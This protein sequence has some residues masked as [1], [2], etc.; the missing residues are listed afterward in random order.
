MTVKT[1]LYKKHEKSGASFGEFG[2][3]E[4]PLWY[5]GGQIKE[6]TKTRE[7]CGL[8]D[9]C[10]MG[11][12]MVTGKDS[13]SYWNRILTNNIEKIKDGQAQYSFMLN[14]KGGVVDDCILYRF[15]ET[16]WMLVV[17]AGNHENDFQWLKEHAFG[18]V[19]VENI[20]EKTGKI[21]IQGPNAPKVIA[22]IAG[23]ESIEKMKFFRFIENFDLGGFSV[24]LSRTGYTGEIGFEIYCD[25]SDAES[26]WELLLNEGKEFGITPAGLGARDT[27]RLE[28]GLPLHGHEIHPD[29]P[30][31]GTPWA[32][33]MDFSTDF[34]GKDAL[35]KA[36][37]DYYVNV[38]LLKSRRKAS[39]KAP[40]IVDG[41]EK[42]FVTSTGLAVSLD[43][44]PLAFIRTTKALEEGESVEITGRKGKAFSAEV[45]KNPL[46]KGTSR[47]KLK[48]FLDKD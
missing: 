39:E 7:E 43:K 31:V 18:D 44:K 9:I 22:K 41:S 33:A 2:G 46:V 13:L 32:F 3:W 15:N 29:I 25:S 8:F 27:L 6:H 4:M 5:P 28:A 37:G 21:D 12:F 40:V 36:E 10:H 17:N 20:S 34:I 23:R 26:I 38:V 19:Q 11:E 1:P 45:K 24:T 42:G 35:E 14:E 30:A 48:L 47:K 16:K